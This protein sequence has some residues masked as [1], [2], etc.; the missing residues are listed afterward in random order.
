MGRSKT[1]LLPFKIIGCGPNS[2]EI[3]HLAF[4]RHKPRR[5]PHIDVLLSLVGW[6]ILIHYMHMYVYIYISAKSSPVFDSWVGHDKNPRISIKVAI[7]THRVPQ[8]WSKTTETRGE[9]RRVSP[10]SHSRLRWIRSR[11]ALWRTSKG[12]KGALEKKIAHYP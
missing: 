8:V 9:G 4:E 12:C 6:F 7:F 3:Q 5:I 10:P 11:L 1:E 2:N